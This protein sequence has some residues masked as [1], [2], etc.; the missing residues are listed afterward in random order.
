[1]TIVAL[2]TDPRVLRKMALHHGVLPLEMPPPAD[3][4]ESIAQADALVLERK[5]AN[6]GD[7]IVLVAGWS[8]AMPNTMNGIIIHTVGEKWA[9]VHP[10]A[11]AG[12]PAEVAR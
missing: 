4:A 7:R 2:S 8:P 12:K 11:T 5:L 10:G 9:V 1:V 6:P 3:M